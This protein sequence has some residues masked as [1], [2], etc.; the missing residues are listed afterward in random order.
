MHS[1]GR[2][3]RA[4]QVKFVY[5]LFELAYSLFVITLEGV[6]TRALAISRGGRHVLCH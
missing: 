4:S 3:A 6:V 2:S 1:G 5:S